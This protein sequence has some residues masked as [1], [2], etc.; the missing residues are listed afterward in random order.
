MNG[1]MLVLFA[2]FKN[3][4]ENFSPCMIR[5]GDPSSL[6]FFREMAWCGGENMGLEVREAQVRFPALLQA[7]HGSSSKIFNLKLSSLNC[8]LKRIYHLDSEN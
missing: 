7:G 3:T 6:L 1:T 5:V 2:Y 8:R 4:K